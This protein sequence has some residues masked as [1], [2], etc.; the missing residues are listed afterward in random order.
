MLESILTP[1]VRERIPP[2]VDGAG[3]YLGVGLIGVSLSKKDL[4]MTKAEEI[5]FDYNS[6]E[7]DEAFYKTFKILDEAN[8]VDECPDTTTSLDEGALR[9]KKYDLFTM[10]T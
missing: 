2:F 10:D 8:V 9:Y 4:E 6:L 5:I 1:I 7:L 3:F